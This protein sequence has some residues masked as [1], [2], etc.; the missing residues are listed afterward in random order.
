MSLPQVHGRKI[1]WYLH[2][3]YIKKYKQNIH[4]SLIN[5][6]YRSRN[7]YLSILVFELNIDIYILLIFHEAPSYKGSPNKGTSK[8]H[9]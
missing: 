5:F 9:L 7:H 1:T 8:F 2:N 6:R 3:F 4:R